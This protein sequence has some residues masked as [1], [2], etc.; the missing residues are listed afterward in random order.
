MGRKKRVL[1]KKNKIPKVKLTE[2]QK[3]FLKQLKLLERTLM[4]QENRFFEFISTYSKEKFTEAFK[5]EGIRKEILF[6]SRFAKILY[7]YRDKKNNTSTSANSDNFDKF[8]NDTKELFVIFQKKAK[9]YIANT[10]KLK[11]DLSKDIEFIPL[12]YLTPQIVYFTLF[13]IFFDPSYNRKDIIPLSRLKELFLT[14]KFFLMNLERLLPLYSNQS[15]PLIMQ[16]SMTL[17]HLYIADN[18]LRAAKTQIQAINNTLQIKEKELSINYHEELSALRIAYH[19]E[20]GNINKA[21]SVYLNIEDNLLTQLQNGLPA[22]FKILSSLKQLA[23]NLE[24]NDKLVEAILAKEAQI[25]I[26]KL[27]TPIYQGVADRTLPYK[28]YR[29]HERNMGMVKHG[30]ET[31]SEEKI[32]AEKSLHGLKS[33]LLEHRLTGLKKLDELKAINCFDNILLSVEIAFS[34]KFY[35][36]L[37]LESCIQYG[38]SAISK[39]QSN[40]TLRCLGETIPGEEK[41][42]QALSYYH[43]QVNIHKK[44]E[45]SKDKTKIKKHTFTESVNKTENEK[46]S[47]KKNIV[48]IKKKIDWKK[49]P[50]DYAHVTQLYFPGN[51]KR[52]NIFIFFD[53]NVIREQKYSDNPDI[54]KIKKIV[55]ERCK[56][57]PDKSQGKQGIRLKKTNSA[58]T[59]KVFK[60]N[61]DAVGKVVCPNFDLRGVISFFSENTREIRKDH[62]ELWV[63]DKI[64]KKAH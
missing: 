21:M 19:F 38:L 44:S 8:L 62:C 6:L 23:D 52:N 61:K 15:Q 17:V 25:D 41:F 7:D 28:T 37:F 31:L 5:E 43:Q 58:K 49:E 18:N 32:D 20:K 12:F 10:E 51:E 56:V 27:I 53:D 11:E 33:K 22:G 59:D 63:V 64:E 2:E 35:A 1:T 14:T 16:C 24:K 9:D 50:P 29:F 30:F 60:N 36:E 57:I 45:E 54:N 3:N 42:W 39:S 46:S 55:Q 13:E 26:Y 48:T 4:R 40:V 34:D 47:S